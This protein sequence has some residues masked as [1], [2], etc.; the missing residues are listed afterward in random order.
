MPCVWISFA[1]SP[2]LTLSPFR[3]SKAFVCKKDAGTKEILRELKK[4][5]LEE[6]EVDKDVDTGDS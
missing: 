2:N 4:N 1:L 3:L 6:R 5:F